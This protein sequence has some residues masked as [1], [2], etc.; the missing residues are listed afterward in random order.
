M[1]NNTLVAYFS[2][3]GTT[4]ALAKRLASSIG[5]DIFEI[6]PT[7]P[8]TSADLDWRDK[9]SRSSVE[10]SD[11]SYRPPIADKME[12]MD[13]YSKIYLGFPIWW[14]GAPTIANTILEQ[15]D[16]R[17]ITI[18]PLATSG[19]SGMG[20]TNKE[21]LPSCKGAVLKEGKRFPA[22]TGSAQLKAWADMF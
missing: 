21:L 9:S 2:A 12:I 4:A 16:L 15:Y 5:A 19:S 13:R 11:K 3:S 17:G 22:D 10:M 6:R 14:Y 8:Y 1:E 18:V 20:Q 7:T